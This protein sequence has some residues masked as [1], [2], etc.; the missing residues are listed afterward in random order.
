MD[1]ATSASGARGRSE[2]MPRS[3]RGGF[4]GREV[5]FWPIFAL[6]PIIIVGTVKATG[7]ASFGGLDTTILSVLLLLGVTGASLL[8]Y[9]H[10]PTRQMAPILLF[11]VVALLGM[12]LGQPGDYQSLKARDFFIL[13]GITVFCVP[14]L[15]RDVRDLRGLILVWF[16]GG[17]FVAALVPIVGGAESLYGR[18]GIGTATHGPAFLAAAALVVGG[19]SLGEKLIPLVVALPAV[20]LN[21]VVLFMVGSRGPLM[22]AA[23]GVIVWLL[24]RGVLHARSVAVLALVSIAAIIGLREASQAAIAHLIL[25]D[26]AR[27]E[28]WDTAGRAFLERPVMGLGWGGFAAISWIDVYPHNLFLETAA[29]LGLVGLLFLSIILALAIRGVWRTRKAP[30]TRVVASAAVVMFVGQ[31]FSSDL[32]N[33]VFWIAVVPC[34]LLPVLDWGAGSAAPATV[35]DPRGRAGTHP[36]VAADLR[37]DSPRPRGTRAR[38]A[39]RQRLLRSPGSR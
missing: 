4:A 39:G 22:G 12:I 20:V 15:L 5:R 25:E 19:A 34:L 27:V 36:G 33:R 37:S 28:L 18:A 10:Y 26:P 23:G 29:E 1:K 9:P 17:T 11:G 8:G 24:L 2:R 14:V 7:F 35:V 6:L 16:T 38:R 3:R 21:G 31:Q 32:T 13:T 30:E